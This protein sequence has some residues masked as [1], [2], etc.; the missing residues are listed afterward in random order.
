M[1]DLMRKPP[2][3]PE[4]SVPARHDPAVTESPDGTNF[5]LHPLSGLLL[6]TVDNIFWGAEALSLGLAIPVA[7]VL[8]FSITL[9]AVTMIQKFLGKNTWGVS[10]TKALLCAFL[11]GIPTSIMG[12]AFGGFIL[13]A[14]GLSNWNKKGK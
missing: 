10:L 8:S 3:I 14:S 5:R 6:I 12:T 11:A 13:L 7:V 1:S 4:E 2:V 9:V